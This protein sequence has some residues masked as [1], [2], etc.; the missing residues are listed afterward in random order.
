[1]TSDKK[2]IMIVLGIG[3]T[4]LAVMIGAIGQGNVREVPLFYPEKVEQTV[5]FE[6]IDGKVQLREIAGVTGES[7][8]K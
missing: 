3:I 1:M 8:P 6:E 4:A 2:F 7:N 5:V